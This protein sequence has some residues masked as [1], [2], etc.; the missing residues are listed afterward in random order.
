M[1]S[2]HHPTGPAP[3]RGSAITRFGAPLLAL[4]ALIVATAANAARPLATDDA[5]V[6]ERRE[7]EWE[8]GFDRAR[9]EGVTTR[10]FGTQVGCG[11]GWRTQLAIGVEHART[12][13]AS[14]TLLR[15]G[16]K[17]RLAGDDDGIALALGYGATHRSGDGDPKGYAGA[18]L[19][20]ILS[21]PI[22]P[23]FTSHANLGRVKPR[24]AAGATTWGVALEAELVEGLDLVGEAT[25]A[26]GARPT[27]AIG[28]RWA[29]TRDWTL[30]ASIAVERTE[31]RTRVL[32]IGFTRPF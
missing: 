29:V 14:E 2:D 1:N 8:G 21:V 3:R 4:S 31:P 12:S 23:G 20:A 11:V 10:V 18:D 13:G 25:G 19:T 24:D 17:T 27:H 22:A 5:G 16:G 28:L 15:L 32:G 7:C 26:R 9:V 6:L 30:D